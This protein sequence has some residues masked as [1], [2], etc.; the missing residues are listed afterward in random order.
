LIC[1][2]PTLT[3]EQLLDYQKRF[4]ANEHP[5]ISNVQVGDAQGAALSVDDGT[6]A[7]FKLKKG[8]K[9][10][11]HLTWPE[12]PASSTCGDGICSEDETATDCPDD[13]M[14]PAGCHGA[15]SYVYYDPLA[16]NLVERREAMRVAWFSGAGSFTD[17][18]TGRREDEVETF[19]DGEWTAPNEAGPV[20]L[21][22][23]LRDSRGGIDWQS[24]VVDV[25]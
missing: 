11:L 22:T 7:P 6:T 21:W 20:H 8:Q 12:C 10:G 9:L 19:S 15:E 4:R 16:R 24:F 1:G 18:H 13:C 23:V 2:L 3:G 5:T 25:E 14:Q 17:D